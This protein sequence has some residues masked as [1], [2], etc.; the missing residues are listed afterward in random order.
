MAASSSVSEL[1]ASSEPHNSIRVEIVPDARHS[2][3]LRGRKIAS[4]R[5]TFSWCD[6]ERVV[7]KAFVVHFTLWQHCIRYTMAY[8]RKRS[9]RVRAATVAVVLALS[10]SEA[11]AWAPTNQ[12]ATFGSQRSHHP[13]NPLALKQPSHPI[14]TP[15]SPVTSRKMLKNPGNPRVKN[16]SS[17]RT[18]SLKLSNSVLASCDTLPSFRTA[19]G[20]LSPETV[21]R[22][23]ERN[24]AGEDQNEALGK[25]LKTYRKSGP[26]SCVPMLSDPAVLPHLT[27][28]MREIAL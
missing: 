2:H 8:Q 7:E 11:S 24:I 17:S 1:G 27:M 14:A 18:D 5:T 10:A 9:N 13:T 21:M 4:H 3:R 26:L 28:A 20:L 23:E 16:K 15:Q 19:H 22:L 25:F 12:K 6:S